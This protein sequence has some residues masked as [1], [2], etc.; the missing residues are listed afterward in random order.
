MITTLIVYVDEAEM[1]RL[2]KDLVA[3]LEIKDLGPHK[4]IFY[5]VLW[6][7]YTTGPL[8]LLK[9]SNIS[10]IFILCQ[11]NYLSLKTFIS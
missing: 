6:F 3:N 5:D 9:V 4:H 7:W 8:T 10:F 11:I 2:K 1:E